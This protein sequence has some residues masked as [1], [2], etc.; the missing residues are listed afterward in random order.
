[1]PYL[2]IFMTKIIMYLQICPIC[3]SDSQSVLMIAG[4][5]KLQCV[6]SKGIVI[7]T[8]AIV[9]SS[10]DSK[11]VLTSYHIAIVTNDVSS[12]NSQSVLT[13]AI[14]GYRSYHKLS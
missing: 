8:I 1:M 6:F 5:H 11:F 4:C 2:Q 13:L 9:I 3:T 12:N 14:V 7:I 10:N